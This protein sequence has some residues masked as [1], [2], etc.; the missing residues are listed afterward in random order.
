DTQRG[1][2]TPAAPRGTRHR[3]DH[4][5]SSWHLRP[6][7]PP[8]TRPGCLPPAK[9]Q[10]IPAS[11]DSERRCWFHKIANVLAAAPKS[12]HPV[13][14]KALAEIWNAENRDHAAA[15]SPV[16]LIA[17]QPGTHSDTERRRAA[18]PAGRGTSG[19]ALA[20]ATVVVWGGD[21]GDGRVGSLLHHAEG[22]VGV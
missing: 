12:A 5:R 11:V 20:L 3:H 7:E 16:S 10:P 18:A 22:V 19:D 1:A 13:A 9:L 8:P 2:A 6:I 14:K 21:P 15:P 17:V 4:P